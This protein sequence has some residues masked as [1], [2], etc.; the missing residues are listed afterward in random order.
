[1]KLR[2]IL[3]LGL[4][5]LLMTACQKDEGIDYDPM[6]GLSHPILID[7]RIDQQ[8]LTRVD[9]G[10]FCNGDQVGLYGV[11]YTNDNTVAG[12]L[13]DE[14]NQVDNARYTYDEANLKWTASGNIYYKDAETNIDLY[15]Y[16][17]YGN[18]ASTSAYQFEV[19]QDQSGAGVTDGYGLSDFLWAKAENVVPSEAKVKLRFSHRLACAHVVLVEGENFVE[20]EFDALSKSVLAMNTIRTAEIDLATGVATATG[21]AESEGIVMKQNSEGFRAI[22]VPQSVAGGK[23]LFSITLDGITYRFKMSE[24]FVYEA[25]KQS[26]FTIQLNKKGHTGEVELQLINTE[27]VDWVADLEAHGGEA[28]QYY[29]VHQEEPGTLGQLIRAAKKNPDKI[30]NLK[31]SGK[32]DG[33]DFQFMRDSMEI[34]QAINLKE[35][36]IGAL[37][38]Y[39]VKVSGD[40]GYHDE[41]FGG[42][43]PDI[44]EAKAAVQARYPDKTITYSS[45][46]QVYL[47]HEIPE[48]AFYNKSSL[49]Y[50][51]FPEKV[52]AI[53]ELAFQSTNLSGAL[54][55]PNDVTAIGTNYS[56]SVASGVFQYTNISSVTFPAGLKVIGDN[57]FSDCTSLCGPLNLPESL[58]DIGEN[59]FKL[60]SMLSGSLA[61]PSKLEK[62]PSDC[63]YDCDFTGDLIIPEGVKVIAGRAFSL[64]RFT[65]LVLPNSLTSLGGGAFSFNRSM[66]GDLVIPP[67]IISIAGE[68]F[69][70]T[71]FTSIVIP[72][73]V[74]EIGKNAFYSN[75]RLT[76]PIVFPESLITIQ[77]SAFNGCSNLTGIHLK[78][79]VTTLQANAFSYC[80]YLASIK[81]DAITPPAI[82]SSTFAGVSKDNFMLEVPEQSII[83][84]QVSTGWADFKQI[85]ANRDFG[86]ERT[87][88]RTM[89]ATYSKSYMLNA[90][91]GEP[92]SIESKP[93]WV[94]VTPASGIGKTEVVVS[95]SEMASTEAAAVTYDVWNGKAGWGTATMTGRRGE[96]TF[97]LDNKDYR[98]T[99]VVEQYNSDNYDGQVITNQTATKGNGVNIVFM[100]DCFDA[101]D[102]AE[103]K[104]LDGINEAIGYYF[105][106][107]P[108]KSYKEYFNI[109]TVVG[110]SPETGMGTVNT[111]KEAKFGSQYALDGITPNTET[112]YE[113]AMK[114][115]TVTE[116]NLCETLVVMVENT[117]DYGGICYTW[118]DGS[119]IAVCPMSRDAYPYDFRG[120]VQHEAGGHGFA[121]LADEYIYHSAFIQSCSCVCCKHID[122]FNAAKSIGWYRNLS[123]NG[124]Y[125]TVE[126]AHLLMHPDYSNIV[127]MYEGGYFHTRGIYRSE[128]TSCM[129]NNIPYYSAIQRQE[130]V[131][132]IKRYA[133]EEFSIEEFYAKD[134]RDASNNTTTRAVSEN[135]ATWSAAS[136][137]W[138]PK[139]MGEKPQL[140]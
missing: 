7:G 119:A 138:M 67:Q 46:R 96:I 84:Y 1:M 61:I 60:C 125:K 79:N 127:D 49:A 123:T 55:I 91:S 93:E 132:R 51:E 36:E 65:S 47:E 8:Y 39:N 140:R 31:V 12:T 44:L 139:Y 74:L 80:Y 71:A 50:F 23:A 124:D 58:V 30:K 25:G 15:A 76:T 137:Q 40:S 98:S 34:L 122:E 95:V 45:C 72:E 19:Q 2:T 70:E 87:H 14:G 112:I 21:E 4:A 27:I 42:I 20:G 130:M 89:N 73:G 53:K 85:G 29:V 32:I 108:Y 62:I 68:T 114:A 10:G 52:T 104:Y 102:I 66:Q 90:P 128:A 38:C 126:W 135:I 63:F 101:K 100:G 59:A 5:A 57:A 28:R 121:K 134:V 105:D 92:W 78:S 106:I 6:Q 110:M 22:V 18:P 75:T 13:L 17:P 83:R 69:R 88:L 43:M 97:L 116:E 77:Q 118:A 136:R 109:Y 56:S 54:I 113:Y 99:M 37:W 35:T 82:T 133:G 131:E 26:K 33:R 11:N 64:N 86:I 3:T 48:R 41:Y 129:N 120:I 103:G 81:C 115:E 94:T 16:Y 107:E 111:I 9:D 117:E 24:G